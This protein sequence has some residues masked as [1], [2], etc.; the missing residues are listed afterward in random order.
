MVVRPWGQL[1][2]TWEDEALCYYTSSTVQVS[3]RWLG[4]LE[5]VRCKEDAFRK[6]KS[7]LV[8][9]ERERCTVTALLIDARLQTVY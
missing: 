5:K 9:R 6:K 8:L 1:G 7:V 4:L 3:G 2:T